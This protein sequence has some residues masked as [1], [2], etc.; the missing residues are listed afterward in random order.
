MYKTY[1][2]TRKSRCSLALAA[3]SDDEHQ[4][5]TEQVI[6]KNTISVVGSAKNF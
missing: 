5:C 1:I 2:K 4:H 3:G 6:S